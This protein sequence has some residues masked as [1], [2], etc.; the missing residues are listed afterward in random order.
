MA[1]WKVSFPRT[2]PNEGCRHFVF[3]TKTADGQRI[4]LTGSNM[5]P[6]QQLRILVVLMENQVVPDFAYKPKTGAQS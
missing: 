5:T 2:A 6:D 4:E 3:S 1:I